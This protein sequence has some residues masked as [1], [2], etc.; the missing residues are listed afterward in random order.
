[1]LIDRASRGWWRKDIRQCT[2]KG[3][4]VVRAR[5]VL[6][7]VFD[8]SEPGRRGDQARYNSGRRC[9][10]CELQSVAVLIC[11]TPRDNRTH[12]GRWRGA[13]L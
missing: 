5:Q 2:R 9:L 8:G 11:N 4:G 7:D 1:M 3:N 13:R 12:I 6:A 10:R